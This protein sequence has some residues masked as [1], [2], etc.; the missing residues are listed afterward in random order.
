MAVQHDAASFLKGPSISCRNGSATRLVS[1]LASRSL[2]SSSSS[3]VSARAD[4]RGA[5]PPGA[6]ALHG[7]EAARQPSLPLFASGKVKAALSHAHRFRC[8]GRALGA[9]AGAHVPRRIVPRLI[10]IRLSL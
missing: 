10:P 7:Y 3:P 9:P 5:T 1:V 2:H 4:A 6:E 8:A